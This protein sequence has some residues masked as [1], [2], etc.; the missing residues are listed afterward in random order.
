MSLS[1]INP[2]ILSRNFNAMAQT[3]FHE[4]ILNFEGTMK[5]SKRIFINQDMK[6]KYSHR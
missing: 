1:P 2:A 4:F 6:V 3:A 5:L